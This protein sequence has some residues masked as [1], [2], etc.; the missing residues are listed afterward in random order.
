MARKKW[1]QAASPVRESVLVEGKKRQPQSK[2][3]HNSDWAVERLPPPVLP[4]LRNDFSAGA[5]ALR[6]QQS[7]RPPWAVRRVWPP[8]DVKSWSVDEKRGKRIP[9]RREYD[10]PRA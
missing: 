7:I 8:E 5:K 10:Q 9:F 6:A 2:W 1:K 4:V 3:I